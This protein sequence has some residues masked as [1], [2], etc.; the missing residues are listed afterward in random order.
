[1]D[2]SSTIWPLKTTSCFGKTGNSVSERR[3]KSDVT[4]TVERRD[5]W[6]E[7][8]RKKAIK[9]VR[10]ART[11]KS[12]V[13]IWRKPH[14]W[15]VPL[16]VGELDPYLT[17]CRLGV[18]LLPYQVVSWSIQPFGHNRH[19]P[20]FIRTQAKR[21]WGLLCP[22]PWGVTGSPSGIL[23]HPTVWPQ[24]INVTDRQDRQTTVL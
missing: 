9:D 10:L 21:K 17:Q 20:R 8:L 15:T 5:I 19:G 22:F 11:R 2:L 16:S 1:M 4:V 18:D 13:E 3:L 24:Y 6:R 12:E 23:I 7:R 14:K